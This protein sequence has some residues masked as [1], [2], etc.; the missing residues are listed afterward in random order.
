MHRSIVVHALVALLALP[1]TGFTM[2]AGNGS[3]GRK[4]PPLT[5]PT[6]VAKAL[7]DTCP[8]AGPMAPDGSVTPWRNHGRYVSCVVHLRNA[9]RKAGCLSGDSGRSIARC[10]A[11]STCGKTGVVLCCTSESGACNDPM[12]A[13]GTAAGTCSNDTGAPC[14]VADDCTRHHGRLTREADACQ[15]GGGTVQQ[16][17]V[18][19]GCEPGSPSGAFLDVADALF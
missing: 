15:A 6:D 16:G 3:H 18:C 19:G 11:R 17:S 4:R 9:L 2:G 12:P 14:D 8:C 10:A 13:D 1:A 7:M 5:C